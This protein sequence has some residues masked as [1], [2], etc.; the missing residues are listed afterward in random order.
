MGIADEHVRRTFL[1]DIPTPESTLRV[2]LRLVS[3]LIATVCSVVQLYLDATVVCRK[4]IAP[5]WDRSGIHLSILVSI[6]LE[7]SPLADIL[8]TSASPN[9]PTQILKRATGRG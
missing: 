6:Y 2:R 4:P 3:P 9:L 7:T 1:P 8:P 5:H